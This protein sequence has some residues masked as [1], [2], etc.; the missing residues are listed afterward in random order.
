[1][2]SAVVEP[3]TSKGTFLSLAA[4][5]PERIASI[6][7]CLAFT[8]LLRVPMLNLETGM[9]AEGTWDAGVDG[10]GRAGGGGR[11]RSSC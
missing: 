1:M 6:K 2:V 10:G 9:E 4:P 11:P 5:V 8:G 7:A 3:H